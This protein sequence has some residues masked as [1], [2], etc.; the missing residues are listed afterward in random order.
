M[1]EVIFTMRGESY[2]YDRIWGGVF[3][4]GGHLTLLHWRPP[5]THLKL[6]LE[7]GDIQGRCSM[8]HASRGGGSDCAMV[9]GNSVT[10]S[11]SPHVLS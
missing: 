8:L 1:R 9:L 10:I 2:Y 4:Y 7:N 11:V 5:P 3:F 6:V